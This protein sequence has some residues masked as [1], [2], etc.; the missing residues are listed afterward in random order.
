V[1]VPRLSGLLDARQA[2]PSVLEARRDLLGPLLRPVAA[3]LCEMAVVSQHLGIA[4][5]TETLHYP[6]CR[7]NEL[8]DVYATEQDG[9]IVEGAPAVDVFTA[10]RLPNEASFA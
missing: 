5:D 1:E 4:P 8:A 2:V 3:D 7:I 10:L 6:P 9:G